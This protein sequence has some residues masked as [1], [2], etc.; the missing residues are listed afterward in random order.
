[1]KRFVLALSLMG[2]LGVLPAPTPADATV[3]E[4]C[5]SE[6]ISSCNSDFPGESE[7]LIAI[8]GWCYAIRWG[9]CEIFD[10]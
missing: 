5:L 2:A 6:A 10:Q 3:V 4:G 9:W 1:M 7:E 8:R